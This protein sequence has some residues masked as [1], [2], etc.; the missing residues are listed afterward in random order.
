MKMVMA[1]KPAA[2]KSECIGC[3]L[4]AKLCPAKAITMKNK[5]PSIDRKNAYAASAARNSAQREQ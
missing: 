4:C 1:S 5:L 2:V 3:G